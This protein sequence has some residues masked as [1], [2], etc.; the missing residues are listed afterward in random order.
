LKRL[1]IQAFQRSHSSLLFVGN[2]LAMNRLVLGSG[3]IACSIMVIYSWAQPSTSEHTLNDCESLPTAESQS[4]SAK[5]QVNCSS[6][7]L[8]QIA[9]IPERLISALRGTIRPNIVPPEM[10]A[11][12]GD[13]LK[14]AQTE[15]N[16][17]RL[18][19][20]I[21]HVAGIPKNSQHHE[22]AQQLQEDWSQE[23]LQRA[24]QS[25]QEAR[26]QSALTMLHAIPATSER[27]TRASELQIRWYQEAVLLH[28]AKTARN[29]G[30]WKGVM[31]ALKSLEGTSLYHS[32]PAQQL[33]Q[34]AINKLYEP[35]EAVMQLTSTTSSKPS[36]LT[37]TVALPSA[38]P[39]GISSPSVD[40]VPKLPGLA[41]DI[42]QALE[43][44]QPK[45]E[46][47]ESKLS[48][49]MDRVSTT[50]HSKSS[51]EPSSTKA[52]ALSK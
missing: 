22:M 51:P 25:Y 44:A 46:T 52:P 14:Q 27:Y 20:A 49:V 24:T 43:W 40:P 13:L 11:V 50:T 32:L 12:Y 8:P 23:L 33:L 21:S 48:E 9:D 41:I 28:Q 38:D 16:S 15:A 5:S 2:F 31:D 6:S 35:D 17:D 3:T 18:A 26:V 39:A 36:D 4:S 19:D 45:L 29:A 42:D 10:E 1:M 7:I 47:N 30:N 37:N 34:Q